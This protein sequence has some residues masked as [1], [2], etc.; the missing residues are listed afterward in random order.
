MVVDA[1][2]A[3]MANS[4][5]EDAGVTFGWRTND[6]DNSQ[7]SYAI[8]Y[9]SLYTAYPWTAVIRASDMRLM[10]EEPDDTYLDIYNIAIELNT[11]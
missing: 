9:S 1:T 5:I 10:Y 7:G 2:S 4:Y 11:P 6:A 3:S 8:A